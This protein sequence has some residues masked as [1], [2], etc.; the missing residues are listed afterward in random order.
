M[1]GIGLEPCRLF[2][3]RIQNDVAEID[4]L[5]RIGGSAARI[6][7][8]ETIGATTLHECLHGGVGEIDR[9]DGFRIEISVTGLERVGEYPDS[10]DKTVIGKHGVNRIACLSLDCRL[11]ILVG[12]HDIRHARGRCGA[13]IGELP[14]NIGDGGDD[15]RSGINCETVRHLIGGIGRRSTFIEGIVL[16]A[17]GAG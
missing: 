14:E 1:S 17:D 11:E 5:A 3:Q 10:A 16:R 9:A 4:V 12:G 6:V 2:G 15:L 7:A 13:T 8:T